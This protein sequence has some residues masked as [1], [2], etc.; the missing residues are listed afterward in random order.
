VFGEFSLNGELI[1]SGPER[2]AL[3]R[4]QHPGK[5]LATPLKR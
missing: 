2:P 3:S 1:S 5:L 4:K